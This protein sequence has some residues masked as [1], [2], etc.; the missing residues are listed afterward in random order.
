MRVKCFEC[1]AETAEAAH[2][3]IRCGAP[4]VWP[5][6]MTADPAEGGP[7]YSAAIAAVELDEAAQR[8]PDNI[9]APAGAVGASLPSEVTGGF[10]LPADVIYAEPSP[11]R[12]RI[13]PL[14]A[15][16]VS[17]VAAVAVIVVVLGW[18][19]AHKPAAPHAHAPIQAPAPVAQPLLINQLR[20][21][22]CLQ[23]P[24]DVNTARSWPHLV[25]AVPC[26]KGHIAEVYFFSANYWPRDMAFPGHATIVHQAR[27]EC[28]KEFRA[29]D[30]VPSSVSVYSFRYISPWNRADWGSG[31]RLLLC[32]ANAGATQPL[33]GSIKGDNG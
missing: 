9:G 15:A 6:P 27:T 31:G 28:R 5:P 29:Y 7:G 4:A 1:G 12:R 23:G 3:C 25:M 2:A 26:I 10:P 24:P 19:S 22:D 11:R 20:P 32:T 18:I 13:V 8:A 33:F 16:A 14:T 30:G 21:G 17:V